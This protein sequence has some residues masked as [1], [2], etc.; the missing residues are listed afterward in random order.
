MNLAFSFYFTLE[1]LYQC[2]KSAALKF[3]GMSWALEFQGFPP[4]LVFT[5][6]SFSITLIT[7]LINKFPKCQTNNYDAYKYN[8]CFDI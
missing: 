5:L 7:Q 3:V 2:F 6:N 4:W 8:T 1:H